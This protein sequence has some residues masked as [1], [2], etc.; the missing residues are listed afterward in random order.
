MEINVDTR[1]GEDDNGEV[2]R[3]IHDVYM[4]LN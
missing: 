2:N 4:H 1:E 3:I